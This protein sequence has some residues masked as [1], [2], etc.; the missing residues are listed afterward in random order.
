MLV[1]VFKHADVNAEI[2][3]G[4]ENYFVN[5]RYVKSRIIDKAC[6]DAY[7]PLPEE[8]VKTVWFTDEQPDASDGVLHLRPWQTVLMARS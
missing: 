8:D 2:L 5:G 6:E 1:V 3:G 7:E 4:F